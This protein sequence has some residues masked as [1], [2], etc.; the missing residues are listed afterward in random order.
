MFRYYV[1]LSEAKSPD[2]ARVRI[3]VGDSSSLHSSEWQNRR[4]PNETLKIEM[5]RGRLY[6]KCP[7]LV[8]FNPVGDNQ[9]AS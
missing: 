7:V 1:T 5:D 3:I 6:V 8:R 2:P 9:E 4:Y